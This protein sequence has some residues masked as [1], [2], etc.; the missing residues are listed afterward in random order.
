MSASEKEKH[1]GIGRIIAGAVKAMMKYKNTGCTASLNARQNEL[2]L[3]WDK[4]PRC[5][6]GKGM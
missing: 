2:H 1:I 6:D 4:D 5:D 3:N